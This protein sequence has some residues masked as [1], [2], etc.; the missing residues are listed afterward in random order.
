MLTLIMNYG[1]T[2]LLNLCQPGFDEGE[3]ADNRYF[4]SNGLGAGIVI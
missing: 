4:I 2:S 3:N 1:V